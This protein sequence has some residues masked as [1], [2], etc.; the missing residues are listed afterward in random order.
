M[1][2][3]LAK[4]VQRN[5]TQPDL[6]QRVAAIA[7]NSDAISKFRAANLSVTT[8][9]WEDCGISAGPNISD[10]TLRT[11]TTRMPIIRYAN[12]TDITIDLT[13]EQLPM[14]VVGNESGSGL[15]Y[16]TLR[17]YLENFHLYCGDPDTNKINLYHERDSHVLTSVQACIL[18]VHRRSVEFAVDLLN[19]Q[20]GAT[21]LVIMATAYGTSAQVVSGGNTILYF[22]NNG[23][24][25]SFKAERISDYRDGQRK[26]L[27][28]PMTEEEKSLN[29]IYIYQ[30]PLKINRSAPTMKTNSGSDS[31]H[32]LVPLSGAGE[33]PKLKRD[34]SMERAILTMGKEKGPYQGIMKSP[35]IPHQL[36]RDPDQPIRLTVQF[37]LCT[38]TDVI[39]NANVED[40]YKQIRNIYEQGLN[41]NS[42][43][44]DHSQRS[45]STTMSYTNNSTL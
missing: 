44:V 8:V 43:I 18:P 22:N 32:L 41:E 23:T 16:V 19:Y 2:S 5:S 7:T 25:R 39:T 45:T 29:S 27:S 12:Y 37:Y 40:I 13:S 33:I 35:G 15:R 4:L 9:A 1:F 3:R 24:S 14:L 11:G 21:V 20:H 26:S 6:V 17:E 30:V 42:L 36:Q 28:E 10:L 31:Y 38:D 34:R